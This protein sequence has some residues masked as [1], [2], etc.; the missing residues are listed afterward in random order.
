MRR[1][2]SEI[3]PLEFCSKFFHCGIFADNFAGLSAVQSYLCGDCASENSLI[4]IA[5][6]PRHE[7]SQQ[8]DPG[9]CMSI[10]YNDAGAKDGEARKTDIAHRVFLHA[11]Y[12][13]IS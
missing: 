13:G 12:A 2:G 1:V 9:W 4:D 3:L 6:R 5:E 7:L 11:H 10:A 8:A